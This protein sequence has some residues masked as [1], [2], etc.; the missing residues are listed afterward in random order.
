MC[1]DIFDVNG[2]GYL[3]ETELMNLVKSITN[4]LLDKMK[5][6]GG[7]IPLKLKIAHINN[8]FRKIISAYSGMISFHDFEF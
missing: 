3:D 7:H 8:K 5:N 2:S 4:S 6:R 1:F